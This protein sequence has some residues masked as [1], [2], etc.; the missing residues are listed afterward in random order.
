[1]WRFLKPRHT[2]QSVAQ[3]LAEGLERG[4]L[5][6][7][8]DTLAEGMCPVCGGTGKVSCNGTSSD[9]PHLFPPDQKE[10]SRRCSTCHGKGFLD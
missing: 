2:V 4:T 6:L 10:P 3:Q 9:G 7:R 1:M 8:P 5:L